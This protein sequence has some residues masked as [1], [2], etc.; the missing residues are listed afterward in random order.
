MCL[1]LI[2]IILTANLSSLNLNI[3]IKVKILI[4]EIKESI[5]KLFEGQL[6]EAKILK[7]LVTSEHEISKDYWH[8]GI[9]SI[10]I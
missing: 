10:N 1:F 3:Q 6:L 9:R 5:R 8:F 4:D 2:I 7:S